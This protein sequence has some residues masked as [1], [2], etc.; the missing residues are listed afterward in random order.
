VAKD[1]SFQGVDMKKDERLVLG[2]PTANL[3]SERFPAP[4]VVGVGREDKAHI[5]FNG[6]PHRCVGS[7]LARI[8][9]QILYE[10]MLALLPPFRL[11][12]DKVATFHGGPVIGPDM[13]DLIW[14]VA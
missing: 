6:G 13:L 4:E 14:D 7:H 8:E 5:V 12:P 2:L 10:R 9:I 1:V 3:D 11:N